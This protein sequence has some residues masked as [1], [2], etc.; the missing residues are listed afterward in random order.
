MISN[1]DEG[2]HGVDRKQDGILLLELMVL[3]RNNIT[4]RGVPSAGQWTFTLK[5]DI[6]NF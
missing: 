2:E 5:L 3:Y 1:D 4:F 6:L